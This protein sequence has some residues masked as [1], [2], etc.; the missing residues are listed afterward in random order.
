M[1]RPVV[2]ILFL[3]VSTFA[4]AQSLTPQVV[5]SS[6]DF[7]SSSNGSFSW[8]LGEVM[9]EAYAQS[10]A[11]LTQGFQQSPT[12]AITAFEEPIA[13]NI[14]VYPNP[15]VNELYL[16]LGVQDANYTIE[17]ID[18]QGRTVLTQQANT[19]GG[20]QLHTLLLQNFAASVY[21]LRIYNQYTQY[22]FR[23]VKIN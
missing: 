9:T 16:K 10:N 23:I 1:L 15:S 7:F 22:S 19:A 6:G 20:R 11:S 18:L 12:L 5:A 2:T 13:N 17:L 8:T 3:S 21:L 14:L 4:L